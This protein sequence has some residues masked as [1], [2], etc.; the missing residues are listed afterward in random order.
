MLHRPN[1]YIVVS[2]I[3]VFFTGMLS[4]TP[5]LLGTLV[6]EAAGDFFGCAVSFG[7]FNND[8]WGDILVG[9]CEANTGT[10]EAYIYYGSSS[11]NT[12]VDVTLD[13]GG[14]NDSLGTAVAGHSSY[15]GDSYTDAAI[16][17][18]GWS[19]GNGRVYIYYGGSPMNYT[20]DVTIWE[21]RRGGNYCSSMWRA[22]E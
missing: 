8:S 2:L 20:V 14:S 5:T 21:E 11:F 17:L 16:G 18:P 12:V 7:N 22:N 6:G 9:A 10:G 4:A 3:V 13:D 1:I 19:S 15:N